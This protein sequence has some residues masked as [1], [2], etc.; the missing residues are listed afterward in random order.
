ML[1]PTI[2]SLAIIE[3]YVNFTWVVLRPQSQ[4]S[5]VAAIL[6]DKFSIFDL[7]PCLWDVT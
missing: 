6:K 4:E 7:R 5:Q 1:L 2:G 3:E